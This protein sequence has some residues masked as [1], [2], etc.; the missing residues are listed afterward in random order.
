MIRVVLLGGGNLA[1][2]LATA[3]FNNAEIELLQIY[4][5]TFDHIKNQKNF[6]PITD[7]IDDLLDADIYVIATSDTAI[8]K[9]S[10]KIKTKNGLV[11]HTSGAITSS[12]LHNK[13]NGVFYPL[14]SFT[15]D[16]PINF[17]NIPFCIETTK[18]ED[19]TLL[20]TLAN[21][22][23]T[24]VYAMN[25]E[26]RKKVHVAAVFVNNFVNYMY[27]IGQDICKENG[28]PFEVLYPLIQE[29]ANKIQHI[30]PQQAQTGPAKRK[31][32]KT[33]ALHEK[34][35]NADQIEVYQLL[36]EIISNKK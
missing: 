34:E 31:D 27:S 28:I 19:F 29:T 3:F 13:R 23:S 1:S 15:K 2:H 20:K 9:I 5:R 32:K 4:N 11:V 25:S 10:K 21:A 6:A 36:S 30:S 16:T 35:L 12:V 26:Q 18:K 17:K 7:S 14:Q 33:V 8:E 22:L 24:K